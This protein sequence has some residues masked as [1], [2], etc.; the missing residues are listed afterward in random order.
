MGDAVVPKVS[1]VVLGYNRF[2]ETTQDCLASLLADPD[3]DDWQL[4]VVDNGSDAPNRDAFEQARERYPRM[5]L[6]RLEENRGYPGGMN[7]GLEKAKGES[8]VLVSS[9]V[10]LPVGTVGC[11]SAAMQAHPDAGLIGPVSNYAG[12]EQRIF[13]EAGLPVAEVLRAG[14]LFADAGGEDV[15]CLAAFR[16]DFC[17]VCLRRGVYQ[18]LGG[19][20]EAFNPGYYEDFDYSLRVRNA[21]YPV[22][23]AEHVFVYHEGGGTFGRVSKETKKLIKRNKG[24][25]LSKHG[26]RVSMPHVRDANIAILDQYAQRAGSATAPPRSRVENR[27][28]FAHSD[29]PR[30]FFKRRRYR[31]R[32]ADVENR[33]FSYLSEE[34]NP[35]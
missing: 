17:C 29:Q 12:N 25:F 2:A 16:L 6:V 18:E 23:I 35:A 27:L 33:L 8:I 22:L 7:A 3:C 10:L 14:G 5:E 1:V 32:L 30:S 24:Y 20:D 15:S 21:G 26:A 31:R 11:L 19:F 4:V 9:D 13:I 28:A 34:G